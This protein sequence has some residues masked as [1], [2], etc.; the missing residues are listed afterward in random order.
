MLYSHSLKLQLIALPHSRFFWLLRFACFASFVGI[1]LWDLF[2]FLFL[3][4]GR[5]KKGSNTRTIMG[6]ILALC[7]YRHIGQIEIYPN[8]GPHVYSN[9]YKR[10]FR[11]GVC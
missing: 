6:S 1:Y 9:K 8:F 10:V 11:L 3:L 5:G 7:V 2:Y 4:H